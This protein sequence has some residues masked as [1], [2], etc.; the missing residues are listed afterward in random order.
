ML[1]FTFDQYRKIFDGALAKYEGIPFFADIVKT[2]RQ[3]AFPKEPREVV[4]FGIRHEGKEVHNR[5]DTADDTISL[6][7][8]ATTGEQQVHEYDGTTEPGDFTEV[9]NPLGDFK[10]S[11]GLYFFKQGLHHSKNP[12]LVQACGVTGMRGGK[13]KPF[14]TPGGITDGTLHLH[15]GILRREH[16]GNW[17]AGCQVIAGGWQGEPWTKFFELCKIATNFPIPYLLVD[18]ADITKFLSA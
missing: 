11:P 8:I 16:V 18:E 5:E 4:I 2:T 14:D 9:L 15:A 12:C 6:V 3:P 7:R 10:M 17:S 1:H 13:G